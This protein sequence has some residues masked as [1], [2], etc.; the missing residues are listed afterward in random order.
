MSAGEYDI[1]LEGK[2][3]HPALIDLAGAAA[4]TGD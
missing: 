2:F 4:T 1:K 3:G